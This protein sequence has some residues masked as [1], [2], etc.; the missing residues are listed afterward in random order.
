MI[1][2]QVIAPQEAVEL[3][4]VDVATGLSPKTLRVQGVDF[5]AVDEVRINDVVSPDVIVLNAREL[6][7]QVPAQLIRDKLTSVTVLSN[8]LVLTNKSLIRFRIGRSPRKVAGMLKL[9]QLFLKILFTTPGTDIFN[10]QLG[11]GALRSIGRNFGKDEGGQIVS[12]FVVSVDN[13]VRQIV[14]IQSRNS[15]IPAG[16]RLLS[17]KV[18]RVGFLKSETALVAAIEVKAQDGRAGVTNVEL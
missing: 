8:R 14:A 12:D 18:L 17:A 7:A 11:G 15:A 2:L 4:R 9:I 13:T 16:E 10:R 6:L 3:T 1:D 5:T